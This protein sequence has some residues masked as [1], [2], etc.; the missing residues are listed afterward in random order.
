MQGGCWLWMLCLLVGPERLGFLAGH[1]VMGLTRGAYRHQRLLYLSAPVSSI[2]WYQLTG[3]GASA[4][5]LGALGCTP[6][7]CLPLSLPCSQG[8]LR[9]GRWLDPLQ[10]SRRLAPLPQHLL[11]LVCD[12]PS[13]WLVQRRGDGAAGVRYP[14]LRLKSWEKGKWPS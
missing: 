11:G 7:I 5:M 10:E 6:H 2:A 8:G 14:A 3:I 4:G 1:R 12:C 9:G 13:G